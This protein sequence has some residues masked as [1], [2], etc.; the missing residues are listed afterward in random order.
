MKAFCLAF[1]ANNEAS[2]SLSSSSS[3][4]LKGS[5]F[6]VVY[7]KQLQFDEMCL[8]VDGA[9]GIWYGLW[10]GIVCVIGHADGGWHR[11][12]GRKKWPQWTD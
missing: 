7:A 1:D 5:R 2:A 6:S 3:S 12:E 10:Y 11:A 4:G 8:H 9:F